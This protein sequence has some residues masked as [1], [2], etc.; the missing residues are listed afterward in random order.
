MNN[1][2]IVPIIMAYSFKFTLR[3]A[4]KPEGP[5]THALERGLVHPSKVGGKTLRYIVAERG[6][7]IMSAT[8][9]LHAA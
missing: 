7:A 8:A 3:Y 2:G 6:S 5:S 1:T 4:R 9:S